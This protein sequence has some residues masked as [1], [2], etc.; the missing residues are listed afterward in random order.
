[1]FETMYIKVKM[2]GFKNILYNMYIYCII[3]KLFDSLKLFINF[4]FFNSKVFKITFNKQEKPLTSVVII[5]F[6]S[7]FLIA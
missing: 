7:A 1:M 3:F 5:P 6:M 2:G 4:R